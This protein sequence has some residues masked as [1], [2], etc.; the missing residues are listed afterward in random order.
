MPRQL[1]IILCLKVE[2]FCVAVERCMSWRGTDVV[3]ASFNI[4][5][6]IPTCQ[7]NF[8]SRI[9]NNCDSTSKPACCEDVSSLLTLEPTSA[10]DSFGDAV[11]FGVPIGSL[12]PSARGDIYRLSILL[13]FPLQMERTS[14]NRPKPPKKQCLRLVRLSD[15]YANEVNKKRS[16]MWKPLLTRQAYIGRNCQATL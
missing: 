1:R 6:R 5:K 16:N 14:R 13:H 4:L 8:N 3:R 9:Y 12:A 15:N 11:G 10:A 2:R 7:D